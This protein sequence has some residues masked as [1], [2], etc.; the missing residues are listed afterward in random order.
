MPKRSDDQ[1]IADAGKWFAPNAASPRG[2]RRGGTTVKKK[3][4]TYDMARLK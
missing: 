4:A 2:I 3:R 1:G